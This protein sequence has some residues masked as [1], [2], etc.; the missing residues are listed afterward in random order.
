MHT[1]T[2]WYVG[3]VCLLAGFSSCCVLPTTPTVHALQLFC[4]SPC[5]CIARILWRISSCGQSAKPLKRLF[6]FFFPSTCAEVKPAVS[7]PYQSLQTCF[8]FFLLSNLVLPHPPQ[9]C[10]FVWWEVVKLCL[11]KA[12]K[13]SSPGPLISCAIGLKDLCPL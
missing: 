10:V 3:C 8:F 4:L 12:S 7:I 9:Q 6:F 13:D 2:Q 1:H 11:R 5:L